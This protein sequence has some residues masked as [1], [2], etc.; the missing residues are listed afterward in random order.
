MIFIYLHALFRTIPNL[1]D[2]KITYL[3]F[4]QF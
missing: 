4:E 2:R 3:H 1:F